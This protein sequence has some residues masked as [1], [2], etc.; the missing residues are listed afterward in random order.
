MKNKVRNS[1]GDEI[2]NLF[3]VTFIERD[4]FLK[5]DEEDIVETFMAMRQRIVLKRS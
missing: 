2:L 1:M 5:V 3:L 4:V